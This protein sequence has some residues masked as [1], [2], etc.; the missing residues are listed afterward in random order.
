M[1]RFFDPGDPDDP[2]YAE[3]QY[4]TYRSDVEW[5]R[6]CTFLRHGYWHVTSPEAWQAIRESGVIRPNTGGRYPT[7]WGQWSSERSLAYVHNWVALFD[8]VSPTEEEVI[9]VWGPAWDSR[10]GH[11]PGLLRGG[12]ETPVRCRR[13]EWPEPPRPPGEPGGRP[14]D[15]R[16]CRLR[17]AVRLPGD[18]HRRLDRPPTGTRK[19]HAAQPPDAER[20]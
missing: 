3:R 17:H 18:D 7:R 10:Q 2:G 11:R 13:R 16:L 9:R 4:A 20:G 14:A 1:E 6:I 15:P 19:R 5:H 8:F 12:C